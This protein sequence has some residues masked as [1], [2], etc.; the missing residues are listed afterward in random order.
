M[1]NM[2]AESL[3]QMAEQA[4]SQG[5]DPQEAVAS[6]V[7]EMLEEVERTTSANVAVPR[8]S[9]AAGKGRAKGGLKRRKQKR[10]GGRQ[11]ANLQQMVE[12][13][14]QARLQAIEQ[15]KKRMTNG[16]VYSRFD[17]ATDVVGNVKEAVSA[18]IWSDGTGTLSSFFINSTQ[19][20]SNPRYFLD[21]SNL[22][23]GSSGSAVQF[24]LAYGNRAGSGSQIV[25]VDNPTQAVYSQYSQTLLAAN[26]GIFTF[27]GSINSD[28]IFILNFERA[29]QKEKVDPGNWQLTLSGSSG[30]A[31]KGGLRTFI[32][33][34]GATT[35]PTINEAGR[36]FNIVTGSIS[37]GINTAAASQT[38]GGVGLFY[39]D[40]G[41]FIFNAGMFRPG[42]GMDI[43]LRTGGP[44][45]GI[46]SGS[47]VHNDNTYKFF[48]AIS[49]SGA[50]GSGFQARNEEDVTSTHYFV[51]VR[52]QEF[53]YSN[54]PTFTSGSNGTF[55]FSTMKDDPRVYIT[56]IGLY[57]D[58]NQ[59]LA[60]A[61]LSKPQL[62]SF[63][64][65]LL[66]KV[67][68]DY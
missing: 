52:N 55:R 2:S 51:R 22:T 31:G 59:L 21:V 35:N 4:Q 62:K 5:L 67:K 44:T 50:A 29:R 41:I 18:G 13:Q 43:D 61:K 37:T 36:V 26:D 64:K 42:N 19:S 14:V 8:I 17:S 47:N 24:S 30:T 45:G 32:D 68:L 27:E 53:N 38:G 20:G 65:E 54:N 49:A 11:G 15:E 56:S 66:V 7:E 3:A 34:S 63:A 28:E 39:P 60:T 25:N 48:S 33:D 23:L 40:Q 16:K 1:G 6:A 57:D 58:A 10:Q 12:S 9:R 46:G